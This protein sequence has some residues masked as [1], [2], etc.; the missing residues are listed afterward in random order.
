MSTF[1]HQAAGGGKVSRLTGTRDRREPEGWNRVLRRRP[2]R[3]QRT[4]PTLRA[5]GHI[6]AAT[7]KAS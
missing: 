4:V 6:A 1:R 3:V 5:D 2:A 7:I